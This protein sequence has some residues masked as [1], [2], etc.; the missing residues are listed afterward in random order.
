MLRPEQQTPGNMLEPTS[1]NGTFS[2]NDYTEACI[3]L[4]HQSYIKNQY[5]KYFGVYLNT[6]KVKYASN[7]SIFVWK[8]VNFINVGWKCMTVNCIEFQNKLP[9]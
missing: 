9:E 4:H 5:N 7:E 1:I 2:I 8:S 3:V 6:Q